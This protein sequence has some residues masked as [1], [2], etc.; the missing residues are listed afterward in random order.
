MTINS[1]PIQLNKKLLLRFASGDDAESLGRFNQSIHEG[2]QP[3]DKRLADW[4]VDLLSGRYPGFRVK[5]CTVVEDIETRKIV[6]SM[7]LLPQ[8][9]TYAGI[10]I[11]V[12]RPELVGTDPDYRKMGLVRKQFEVLHA[13][14]DQRGDLI[15]GIT[16][17]PYYYRQFGYEM[18]VDLDGYHKAYAPQQ[19]PVLDKGETESVHFRPTT[20]QDLP[21]VHNWVKQANNHSLL[22]CSRDVDLW[23]YELNGKSFDSINRFNLLT[24]TSLVG[25]PIGI[26]G[27]PH[28]LWGSTMTA[29]LYELSP[30]A[31][32]K[33]VTPAVLRYIWS[34]G[35]MTRAFPAKTCDSIALALSSNHPAYDAA[36]Q[37]LTEIQE[38]YAWYLRVPH[39][40]TLIKKIAPVLETRLENTAFAGIDQ[41]IK[42]SFYK[43]GVTIRIEQGKISTVENTTDPDWEKADA[44]FPNLTFLQILFGHRSCSELKYAYAD[45]AF[46]KGISPLLDCLFP[47]QSS[48]LL[49]MS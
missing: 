9:W 13:I 21:L 49:A 47:K 37:Y 1:L 17:I 34:T 5:D 4:T 29:V 43:S 20:V 45:C 3:E 36:A 31:S 28:F 26:F 2:E 38:P 24:I 35:Q 14:S 22:S 41:E 12:S 18:A 48:N 15:Q 30:A 16:G 8:T 39:L 32:W 11:Q 19:I 23:Q 44:R 6:S 7:L 42:I 27:L 46:K 10:P 33:A 40:D 25:E